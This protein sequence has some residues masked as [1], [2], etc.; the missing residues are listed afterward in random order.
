MKNKSI[1]ILGALSDIAKSI[2][3]KYGE[4]FTPCK[5]LR[6]MA[7]KNESFHSNGKPSQVA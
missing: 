4:R 5:L 7:V 2:A 1:L 3:Q 6:D